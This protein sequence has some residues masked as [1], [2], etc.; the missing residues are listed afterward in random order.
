[1]RKILYFFCDKE[2]KR[3]YKSFPKARTDIFAVAFVI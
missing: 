1:M 2:T 3:Y